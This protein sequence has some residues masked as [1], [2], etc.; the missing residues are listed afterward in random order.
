MRAA[1]GR[2][3]GGDRPDVREAPTTDRRAGRGH[4]A[5]GRR[6]RVRRRV[7]VGHANVA[8]DRDRRGEHVRE[9]RRGG[10][11]E[12]AER[13]AGEARIRVRAGSELESDAG[14]DGEHGRER[15][16]HAEVRND[17]GERA[18]HDGGD[19]GW[20]NHSDARRG[21]EI[22]HRLRTER[23]L[24]RRGGHA[25]GD[26]GAG[27]EDCSAAEAAMRRHRAISDRR[28]GGEDGG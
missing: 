6:R 21:S 12:R 27:G 19:A 25:G 13:G 15:S 10:A 26:R 23:A 11:E 4:G 24:F 17:E 1:N 2:G 8:R 7:R 16:E 5:R 9:S 3:G 14:R 18:K 28:G 20:G 22:E